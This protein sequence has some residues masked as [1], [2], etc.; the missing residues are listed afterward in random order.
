MTPTLFSALPKSTED[1]IQDGARFRLMSS[2][3]K[4]VCA[5]DGGGS[6]LVADREVPDKWET[7]TAVLIGDGMVR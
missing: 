6:E 2:H 5:E 3:E 7:F 4:W 1:W